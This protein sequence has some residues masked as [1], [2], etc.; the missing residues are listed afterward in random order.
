MIPIN[1]ILLAAGLILF[2]GLFA[3][4]VFKKTGLPDVLFLILLG[5]AIGPYGLKFIEPKQVELFAPIFTTFALLFLLF[6]GAFN[7]D[8]ASLAKGLA[9][10]MWITIF[11]FLISTLFVTGITFLL[12]KYFFGL[13]ILHA[14]LLGFILGGICG[15]FV[16]PLLKDLPISK[17]AASILTLESAITDVFSIVGALTIL[18]LMTLRTFDV[19]TTISTIASIFAVAGLIGII[20]GIAWIIIC[21]KLFREHKSYMITIAYVL[22]VYAITEYLNGNGAI[23]ALFLGLVL[24]N[25]KQLTMIAEG[26]VRPSKDDHYTGVAVTTPNE[27][28]FYSQISFFLKTFFFVYIGVLFSLELVDCIKIAVV[29]TI[30]LLLT[31]NLSNTLTKGMSVMDRKMINSMFARG[32]AAAAIAQLALQSNISYAGIISEITY[33]V[34]GFTVLLSSFRVWIAKRTGAPANSPATA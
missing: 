12:G 19:R 16:I 8:L 15:A 9:K 23:A 6:D 2:F 10:T 24:R 18:E 20:A 25:S 17:E 5:F 33:G 7:I 32:L 31:R 29:I 1:V 22:I 13:S 4:F 34:I 27:E 21:I 28:F 11:N 26:I 30:A 3:E 14:L